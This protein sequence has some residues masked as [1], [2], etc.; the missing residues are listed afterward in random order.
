MVIIRRSGA[1]TVAEKLRRKLI[2]TEV[3]S[4]LGLTTQEQRQIDTIAKV[5]CAIATQFLELFKATSGNVENIRTINEKIKQI[6]IR[7]KQLTQI[8]KEPSIAELEEKIRRQVDPNQRISEITNREDLGHAKA[9]DDLEMIAVTRAYE[10]EGV[11]LAF[12]KSMGKITQILDEFSQDAR[13]DR[14]SIKWKQARLMIKIINKMSVEAVGIVAQEYDPTNKVDLR[15]IAEDATRCPAMAY[16]EEETISNIKEIVEKVQSPREA[17]VLATIIDSVDLFEIDLEKLE[18]LAQALREIEPT[19]ETA[20]A[21][22]KSIKIL[23]KT[24]HKEW[25]VAQITKRPDMLKYYQERLHS[26][27]VT[28]VLFMSYLQF[29]QEKINGEEVFGKMKKI[30]EAKP[31]MGIRLVLALPQ[32]V[33]YPIFEEVA[34]RIERNDESGIVA[35]EKIISKK[36]DEALEALYPKTK[37]HKIKEEGRIKTEETR[38]KS[39]QETEKIKLKQRR[40]ILFSDETYGRQI[41][42]KLNEL[43]EGEVVLIDEETPSVKYLKS[44]VR[45]GDI[46]VIDAS[47]IGHSKSGAAVIACRKNNIPYKIGKQTNAQRIIDGIKIA[48]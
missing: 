27:E 45:D 34:Q 9:E 16:L 6:R 18:K 7:M 47:H 39:K 36:L 32:L 19:K 23:K 17:E 41:E 33:H 35:V 5:Q 14:D 37:A 44:I 10:T 3:E 20:N 30:A 28:E 38:T 13:G 42:R 43:V 8:S 15:R 31:E 1:A 22:A 26:E 46:V 24:E 11:A 4:K 40:I 25:L 2:S 29:G 48:A 21:I 12:D